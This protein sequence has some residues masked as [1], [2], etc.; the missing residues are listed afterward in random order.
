M[1][2][3]IEGI[4]KKKRGLKG[5]GGYFCVETIRGDLLYTGRNTYSALRH[6]HAYPFPEITRNPY[7]G[8][9]VA[10][11]RNC[12]FKLDV[13]TVSASSRT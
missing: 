12:L 7:P 6:R 2:C 4:T 13:N 9:K 5:T 3:S 11:E 8:D 1:R 10:E